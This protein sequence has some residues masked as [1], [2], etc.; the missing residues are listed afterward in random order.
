MVSGTFSLAA[1]DPD[2]G[3]STQRHGRVPQHRRDRDPHDPGDGRDPRL[4][5][6]VPPVGRDVLDSLYSED[7]GLTVPA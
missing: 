2:R 7:Y 6:R 5:L 4:V 3:G 1:A